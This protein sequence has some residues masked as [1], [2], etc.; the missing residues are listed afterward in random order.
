[1]PF[2][3]ETPQDHYD[4]FFAIQGATPPNPKW[5]IGLRVAHSWLDYCEGDERA[6]DNHKLISI[7]RTFM[8]VRISGS[9]FLGLWQDI[10]KHVATLP[11]SE[12][13]DVWLEVFNSA[14]QGEHI[15]KHN[16]EALNIL[17]EWVKL[18]KSIGAIEVNEGTMMDIVNK[19]YMYALSDWDWLALTLSMN[20]WFKKYFDEPS[21]YDA[22]WS[23][24]KKV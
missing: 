2:P 6:R 14:N 12:Q 7:V 16:E 21:L 24:F 11:V 18:E 9:G 8:P 10:T 5:E 23:K 17:Q 3:P 22:V 1:M 15:I 20:E 4:Y 19:M 13:K